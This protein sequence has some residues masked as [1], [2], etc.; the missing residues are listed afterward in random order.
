MKNCPEIK[1]LIA[2]SDP[3]AGHVGTIYK[4]SG[5]I[6]GGTIRGHVRGWQY[7]TGGEVEYGYSEI[8][9]YYMK[10]REEIS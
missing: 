9:R 1:T 8:I 2:Y 3:D 7:L 10:L 6:C 5:F 4:A